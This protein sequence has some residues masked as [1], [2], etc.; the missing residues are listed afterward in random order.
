MISS[1]NIDM[2]KNNI[3]VV[4]TE[5]FEVIAVYKC[6]TGQNQFNKMTGIEEKLFFGAF[7]I[8]NSVN[9]YISGDKGK[10]YK[11]STV[12]SQFVQM[13]GIPD[14]GFISLNTLMTDSIGNVYVG[15]FGF[16]MYK[17]LTG[18]TQFNPIT[19][20]TPEI[21]IP[22]NYV[23]QHVIIKVI[24][25]NIVILWIKMENMKFISVYQIKPNLK[26]ELK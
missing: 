26:N 23:Y 4:N 2:I 25:M 13:T 12:Q 1:F 22:R 17:C 24:Y 9:I 6:L 10:V 20:W 3:F 14:T 15:M 21:N 5:D 18:Q 19:G 11:C 7:V 8:D 16:I